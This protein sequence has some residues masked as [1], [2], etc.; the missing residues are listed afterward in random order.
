MA[1]KVRDEADVLEDNLRYHR[2]Q[3]VDHFIVTDNGST[4]GTREIMRRHEEAG[5][6]TLIEEPSTD[7]FRHQEHWRFTRMARLARTEMEG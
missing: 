4:D 2:A 5:E 3:G 7:A 1:M 6:L